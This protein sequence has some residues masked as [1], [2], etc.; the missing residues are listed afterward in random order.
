MMM[1]MKS[2]NKENN[3]RKKRD[4]CMHV[5]LFLLHLARDGEDGAFSPHLTAHEPENEARQGG[6]RRTRR[7]SRKKKKDE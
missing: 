3:K 6:R 4:V 2:R 1:K 5:E 7:K